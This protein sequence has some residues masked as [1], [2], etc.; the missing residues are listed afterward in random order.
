MLSHLSLRWNLPRLILLA[1]ALTSAMPAPL[2]ADE[3]NDAAARQF[4]E[5]VWPVLQKRCVACHGPDEQEGK[6]RLDSREGTI[7]GGERGAAIHPGKPDESLLLKTVRHEI[8]DLTMPPKE[9]LS[10]REL[11]ALTDWIKNGA[12]WPAETT[13]PMPSPTANDGGERIGDAWNDERNPI[14]KIFH[15]ERLDLWSLK[16]VKLPMVPQVQNRDWVRN[17]LDAF[18]LA[19][20]EAEKLTPAVEADRRA[21][22]RRV[23][24]DL[25][26][27]PPT[28]QRVADFV[29]DPRPDAYERLVDELLASPAYGEH[30]ARLWLD[31]VRYS[32]SNGFDWDEFRPRAWLFR[33]YVVRSLNQDKSFDQFVLEHLAGDEL[34]A[35]APQTLAEQD[36]LLATSYLR[37]GPQDN[38]ASLFNEQSR[39]RAEWMADLVETT[40][41]AFLGLTFS[42]CRCHDHKF[43]PLSQADH[44]RLRAFFE[45]LKYADDVPINLASEQ[46][47]IREH[48]ARLDEEIEK[49]EAKRNRLRNEI[50]HRVRAAKLAEFTAEQRKLVETPPEQ[51]SEGDKAKADDLRKRLEVSDDEIKQAASK[52]EAQRIAQLDGELE[53]HRQQRREFAFALLATDAR[54]DIPATHILYQ[55]NHKEER[56]EVAAGFISILDPNPAPPAKPAAG[57]TR[58]RR[59]AL[60]R[61]LTSPDN[62]LTA[63]VFVNRIWQQHFGRGL[64]ATPNDFGFAGTPPTH[65][66]LLDHLATTF[67]HDGWSIKQLQRRIVTSATYRQSSV[68]TKDILAA[69]PENQLYTRQTLRRLTAEQL[70][71]ALLTTSGLLNQKSSGPPIW[72]E[73]PAEILQANP[74]FLDDN[75]TR[76]KGW[77]PSPAEEQD[78]RSLYLVQKRTVRIPFLETFDLPENA[79]SCARRN[80]STV[81]PQALS[82]LNSPLAVRAAKGL[83]ERVRHRG[84]K[85]PSEQVSAAFELAL[86][87]A[88]TAEEAA[89]CEAFLREQD[90]PA[91]CRAL[92]NLNEFAYLD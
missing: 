86:A 62:P 79:T 15:G 27:L 47:E 55:G 66:E 7:Q 80:V 11:A 17:P 57:T 31:V 16:P 44:F 88:P 4:R 45:P 48:N 53:A 28:R 37:I 71:D 50:Q 49:L 77:Y 20:I 9:K 35:G 29:A 89:A 2:E 24:F 36:M 67:A 3:A 42:C 63:R 18:I 92:L 40:G 73:L 19:K 38:S 30:F 14:V 68:A 59:L 90:L 39:A 26:G 91:L 85:D 21:L 64:V 23:H 6:L 5:A 84:G 75:A 22:C 32:D 1:L 8:A 60:A 13:S 46:A 12:P 87:R 34:V 33:D 43:D 81:A 51:L 72:P 76:T 70:R 69:D 82:L 41:S 74:A 10:A 78:A 61:W 56:E 83:A 25:T 52:Q 58:G 54:D 65:P